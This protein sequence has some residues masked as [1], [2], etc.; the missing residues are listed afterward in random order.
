MSSS[1]SCSN[2]G[3]SPKTEYRTIASL[4]AENNTV[5]LHAEQLRQIE[6]RSATLV[7]SSPKIGTPTVRSNN[8]SKSSRNALMNKNNEIGTLSMEYSQ[9]GDS[10]LIGCDNKSIGTFDSTLLGQN[11]A[12]DSKS[13]LSST[14]KESVV[15]KTNVKDKSKNLDEVSEDQTQRT[16]R[17]SVCT[18]DCSEY[19]SVVEEVPS[20]EELFAAGWAK[21]FD[22]NSGC[23]YYFTLDRKKTCWENP[24][25]QTNSGD[26]SVGEI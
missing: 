6:V 25:A 3:N 11:F 15:T 21:A 22:S 5:S 12:P 8:S 10:T 14:I 19:S 26:S 13:H 4:Q 17:S 9:D 20:D 7:Q 1:H 16:D 24:L 2:Q 18:D 23:H